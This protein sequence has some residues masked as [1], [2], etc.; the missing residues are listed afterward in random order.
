MESE[1]ALNQLIREIEELRGELNQQG[2]EKG[3]QDEDVLLKSQELD[4]LI[5]KYYWLT[6]KEAKKKAKDTGRAYFSKAAVV[7]ILP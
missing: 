2:T 7:Q 4:Q 6:Q 5:I 3:F 1:I